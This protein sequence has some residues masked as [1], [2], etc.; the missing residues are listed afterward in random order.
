MIRLYLFAERPTEQT[1]ADNILKP[2][3]AQYGVFLDKIMAIKTR[4]IG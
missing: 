1:F 2:H 3:L 4:I